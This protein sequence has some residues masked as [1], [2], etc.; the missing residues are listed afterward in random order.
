MIP[1][2]GRVVP[3][4]FVH[5]DDVVDLP[6]VKYRAALAGACVVT[7]THVPRGRRIYAPRGVVQFRR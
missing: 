6:A 5:P 4:L 7:D 3:V 1:A 2:A